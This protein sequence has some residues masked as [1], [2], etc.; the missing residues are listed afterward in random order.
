ESTLYF[1]DLDSADDDD[2]DDGAYGSGRSRGRVFVV[3][4]LVEALK[5][6][7][8]TSIRVGIDPTHDQAA[9]AWGRGPATTMIIQTTGARPVRWQLRTPPPS[10]LG[11]PTYA[12]PDDMEPIDDIDEWLDVVRDSVGLGSTRAK[13]HRAAW[14]Q[15]PRIGVP[16]PPGT[17]TTILGDPYNTDAPEGPKQNFWFPRGATAGQPATDGAEAATSNGLPST[18]DQTATLRRQR[19]FIPPIRFTPPTL[20][21]KSTE[22]RLVSASISGPLLTY[23]VPTPTGPVS[24]APAVGLPAPPQKDGTLGRRWFGRAQQPALQEQAASTVRSPSPPE[25]VELLPP[26]PPDKRSRT[27]PDL[28]A[29]APRSTAAAWMAL[30]NRAPSPSYDAPGSSGRL[31][32]PSS[33]IREPRARAATLSRPSPSSSPASPGPVLRGLPRRA[34]TANVRSPDPDPAPQP[35]AQTSRPAFNAA[36]PILQPLRAAAFRTAMPAS[37]SVMP[38]AIPSSASFSP[39]PASALP[40]A[41]GALP[42][43]PRLRSRSPFRRDPPTGSQPHPPQRARSPF[44]R[45][46]DPSPPSNPFRPTP[47]QPQQPV[48]RPRSP[49][50]RDPQRQRSPSPAPAAGR[51]RMRSPFRREPPPAAE[52]LLLRPQKADLAPALQA[53]SPFRSPDPM[54]PP[55]INAIAGATKRSPPLATV[56]QQQQQQPSPVPS[57]PPIPPPRPRPR[58]ASR[59]DSNSRSRSRS[60]SPHGRSRNKSSAPTPPLPPPPPPRPPSVASSLSESGADAGSFSDILDMLID[61]TSSS[62]PAAAAAAVPPAAAGARADVARRRHRK[63]RDNEAPPAIPS[64]STSLHPVPPSVAA[65]VAAAASALHR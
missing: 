6:G 8:A 18:L 56:A 30:S 11:G 45:D 24:A 55:T 58:R 36:A 65:A 52:P 10:G 33:N 54:P 2:D 43:A 20:T 53:R 19:F 1:F 64:R 9:D 38:A 34:A 25:R 5:I 22:D 26:P 62:S 14:E 40:S 60:A 51:A 63:R 50:R 28:T 32:M 31:K 21:R 16:P 12:L 35:Y 48:L 27:A 44:R 47:P 3:G 61:S 37:A 29:L 17:S 15:Q 59:S 41:P 46:R 49:F 23:A 7:E 39:S 42:S 13:A 4:D 57:E